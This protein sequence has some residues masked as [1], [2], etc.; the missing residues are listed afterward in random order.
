MKKRST[1]G[2]ALGV[3][4]TAALIVA[5]CAEDLTTTPDS[6]L[7][8]LRSSEVRRLDR[9]VFVLIDERA[10]SGDLELAIRLAGGTISISHDVIG[11]FAVTGLTDEQASTLGKRSDVD[12]ISR[13]IS[14]QWIP[15]GR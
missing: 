13:D 6:P 8:S 15:P 3:V 4:I 10:P 5:G 14:V 11:V 1:P 2:W 7:E 9:H 12:A